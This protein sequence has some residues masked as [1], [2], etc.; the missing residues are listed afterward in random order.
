[1]PRQ[2]MQPGKCESFASECTPRRTPRAKREPNTEN[3]NGAKGCNI[4]YKQKGQ[5]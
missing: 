2:G 3:Y 5:E 4:R 1:M